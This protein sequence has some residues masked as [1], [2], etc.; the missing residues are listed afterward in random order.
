[1]RSNRL[2]DLHNVKFSN[3]ERKSRQND[4]CVSKDKVLP[5]VVC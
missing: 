5:G 1:M 4:R 3:K 2:L